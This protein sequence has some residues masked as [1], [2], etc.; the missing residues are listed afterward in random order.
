MNICIV[1]PPKTGKTRSLDTLV[2]TTVVFSSDP[3]GY[4]ALRRPFKLVTPGSG[5][6]CQELEGADC[7]VVDYCQLQKDLSLA[8]TREARAPYGQTAWAAF[9]PDINSA[10]TCAHC[11]NIVIDGLTGMSDM[12]LN[13]VIVMNR[14]TNKGNLQ[15][16]YGDAIEKVKEVVN[17]CAGS[18]KNFVLLCHTTLEKDELS[19]RL[20]ERPLV[21]GRKL[22]DE[23]LAMFSTIFRTDVKT[24]PNNSPDYGW[25]TNPTG[26]LETV[27]SR[28]KDG[29]PSRIAQDFKILFSQEA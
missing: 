13:A 11:Q 1:G 7:V 24:G 19:G 12:I 14:A 9:V 20:V 25:L 16:N 29:L 4:E 3:G 26:L 28:S 6:L 5:R 27:G 8:M 17:I 18:K 23:L 15:A 22:P 2:G 21:Y 10:L